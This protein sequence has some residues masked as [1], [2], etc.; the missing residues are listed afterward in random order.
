MAAK[1][2]PPA[3]AAIVAAAPAA[4][5][6]ASRV[7]VTALQRAAEHGDLATLQALLAAG[8]TPVDALDARGRTALLRA[9]LAGQVVTARALLA[10]G[11]DPAHADADGLT[12]RDAAR[13]RGDAAMA[14]LF[15]VPAP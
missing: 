11:A 10:A 8:D 3:R 2:A 14:Q 13:E 15:A 12:P 6:P 4:M 5:D 7:R 9:V 1:A